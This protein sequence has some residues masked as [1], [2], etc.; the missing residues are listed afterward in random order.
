MPNIMAILSLYREQLDFSSD[1][2]IIGLVVKPC[3]LNCIQFY[4]LPI[5]IEKIT[6]GEGLQGI[7][8]Y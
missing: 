3:K 7:K 8:I 6:H 2:A 5:N 1:N 4:L